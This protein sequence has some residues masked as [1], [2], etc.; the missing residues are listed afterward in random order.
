MCNFSENQS[1]DNHTIKHGNEKTVNKI[2]LHK[3]V[4]LTT[5]PTSLNK[6]HKSSYKDLSKIKKQYNKAEKF[7]VG[8]REVTGCRCRCPSS[9]I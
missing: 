7:I 5:I 4:L 1:Y 3:N 2:K 9:Q 8:Y 6:L